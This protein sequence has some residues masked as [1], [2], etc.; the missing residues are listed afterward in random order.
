MVAGGQMKFDASV[1]PNV[2]IYS[3]DDDA[4]SEGRD[5][6]IQWPWILIHGHLTTDIHS[7][8]DIWFTSGPAKIDFVAEMT[9]FPK[10]A[11]LKSDR[12]LT[13]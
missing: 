5:L 10:N 2:D 13:I 3:V 9:I 7:V 6:L 4:W 8:P 12:S 1:S 11:L